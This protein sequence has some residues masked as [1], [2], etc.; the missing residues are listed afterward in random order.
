MTGALL[1]ASR[2][3][4]VVRIAAAQGEVAVVVLLLV[5]AQLMLF[6][7]YC[8]CCSCLGDPA[9]H[10]LMRSKSLEGQRK[11]AVGV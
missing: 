9:G 8:C 11:W 3:A 6:C 2:L 1:V 7:C 5:E 4:A 10:S